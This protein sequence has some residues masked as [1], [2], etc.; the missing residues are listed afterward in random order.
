MTNKNSIEA[1]AAGRLYLETRQAA[2][3][4]LTLEDCTA[5]A[6]QIYDAGL[7]CDIAFQDA[8][9]LLRVRFDIEGPPVDA[10]IKR[11]LPTGNVKASRDAS[12]KRDASAST[13]TSAQ[14]SAQASTSVRASNV[15][16]L[17]KPNGNAKPDRTIEKLNA[18]VGDRIIR[19]TE[20]PIPKEPEIDL[21]PK[22]KAG[23]QAPAALLLPSIEKAILPLTDW[24]ERDL[25]PPDPLLG[26][27]LTTTSGVL[28]TAPTG[29]GKSM[30]G[31]ALGM[32]TAGG[33]SFLRW[34]GRRACNVLYVDGEMSN[35]LL[36]ER[37]DEEAKRLGVVPAGFHALNHEDVE[38]LAP[39]NTSQGQDMIE[40]V[41]ARIGKVELIIFDNIMSLVAGDMRE[42]ESWRQT[43]P[44]QLSLTKRK[45]G[46]LWLH[47]T[48]HDES[49]SYG[50]KTRE[51]QMDTVLFGSTVERP[52]ADV[53]MKIEFRKARER[54]PQTRADFADIN[55]ALVAGEWTYSNPDGGTK[56]KP[57]PTGQKFLD[58][59]MNALAGDDATT[60]VGI[61][62]VA[63]EAWKRECI[64]L[65]LVDQDKKGLTALS[66]Y[67]VELIT[68]N[69]IACNETLAW[70][71]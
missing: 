68:R 10:A 64:A 49:R 42:E 7:P 21:A 32:G 6:R 18:R 71:L 22:A 50:T 14:P 70:A 3:G 11:G 66:K 2:T 12:P 4:K 13:S 5:V 39:L 56:S 55:V 28:F 60:S 20:R 45:I 54:T 62:R 26:R 52:E 58:A 65:G 27:W 29:A 53:S 25:P 38:N 17:P 51:W 57:S 31:V 63:I 47:H 40:A 19:S 24:L 48:G 9:D 36:K 69:Q 15:H 41:I 59:L 67:K 35:R 43:I 16:P 8:R 61:R 33:L 34:D 23:K 37:L 46:Q 1:Q 44:F 30:C